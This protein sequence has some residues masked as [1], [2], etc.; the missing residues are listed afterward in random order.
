MLILFFFIR[1]RLQIVFYIYVF[2]LKFCYVFGISPKLATGA[3]H[4]ILLDLMTLIM[5][6]E[7]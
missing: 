6:D 2:H 5:L 7:K 1:L 4:S 3:S